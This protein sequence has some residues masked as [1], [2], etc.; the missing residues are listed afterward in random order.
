MRRLLWIVGSLAALLAV[1]PSTARAYEDQATL[2]LAIGYAGIPGSDSVPRNGI[3]VGLSAGGGFGDAWSIQ[4]LL[5]YSVFP[6]ARALHVGMAGIEAVYALDIVRFVPLLGAGLDGLL[7]VRERPARGDFALH[8]L[9]GFDYL[10]NSRW[11]VGA[12]VRGYWVATHAQS[13][14]APF[15]ITAA[16][17]IGVRFDLH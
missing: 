13:P 17:R 10:I 9:V 5:S 12:D 15:L 11:C 8:F 6:N 4:G 1:L 2:G 7:T 14:L 16:A 3:D